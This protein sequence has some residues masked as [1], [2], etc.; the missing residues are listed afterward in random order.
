MAPTTD[1]IEDIIVNDPLTTDNATTRESIV[2]PKS[3]CV[4]HAA[5]V[6]DASAPGTQAIWYVGYDCDTELMDGRVI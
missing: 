3:D 6:D 4:K 5:D 1:D 2:A